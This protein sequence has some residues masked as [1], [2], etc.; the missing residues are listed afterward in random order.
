MAKKKEKK[1]E[2]VPV[3]IKRFAG[4]PWHPR[5]GDMLRRMDEDFEDFQRWM[6]RSFW[7]P[8]AWLMSRPWR[9]REW[10]RGWPERPLFEIREP[11][12]DIKDTGK[13]IVVEAE[14]AGIPKENIDISL[15][16]DSIEISGEM[17][18][19]EEEEE[20]GYYRHER[21]YKTCLRQMP[22]PAEVIPNK[23]RARLEGGILRIDIPKKKP[24]PKRKGHR[25]KIE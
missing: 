17:E 19:K 11:L 16:E 21:S 9:R 5:W 7:R 24:T 18:S 23:A 3:E 14:M 15:T 10:L 6:D 8:G 25:V 4:P 13:E 20:E 22:L 2:K 1:E 12:V